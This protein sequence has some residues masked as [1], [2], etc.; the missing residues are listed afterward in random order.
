MGGTMNQPISFSPD[1]VATYYAA[2]VPNLKQRDG[3]EWRGPCPI[4]HGHGDN[5]AVEPAT[6]RWH[7]HSQCGRGGDV[8]ALEEA[9][10]GGDFPTR[11]AE[12]LRIVGRHNGPT[13]GNAGIAKPNGG[14]WE[15]IARYPYVDES[16]GLLFEAVRF[17]KPN[18]QKAFVQGRHNDKGEWVPNLESVRRVPYRLPAVLQTETVYLVEGEKDVATLEAW[19]LVASCNPGGSGSSKLYADW[20]G[21]FRGRNIVILPD[22]DQPGRKHAAAVAAALMPSAASVRIV[23]LAGLPPKGDVTDWQQAGGTRA[24]LEQLAAAAAPYDPAALAS[25]ET[26]NDWP[27]PEP[28][29]GALPPVVPFDEALLPE[30]FRPLVRDLADRMQVPMD[31]PAVIMMLCLAGAVNRRAVIQPKANDTGWLVVPNLWGGIVAPPGFMKSPVIGAATQ[32]LR[33][34]QTEWQREHE[35]EV[36]T[37]A[38]HK[39]E[40]ELRHSAWKEQSKQAPRRAWRHP[41]GRTVIRRNRSGGG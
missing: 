15:E 27:Q 5:F 19:N 9:L 14:R 11:K 23:E 2:R 21:H 31:F 32:P 7:C 41:R 1:E 4:H 29:E 18:G 37:Y 16:G 22:H 24:Q 26:P 28:L 10:F 36:Q 17:R 39:E 25:F 13:N 34:I 20:A 3:G 6:G 40:Y 8:L 33:Q 38:G 35:A 30:S 12:V